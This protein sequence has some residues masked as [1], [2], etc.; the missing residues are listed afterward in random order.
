[1]TAGT[2]LAAQHG[3]ETADTYTLGVV[4][5][6]PGR[7]EN[8]TASLDIYTIEITDVI[9]PVNSLFVY[10]QC[11][12]ADGQ[13][14]PSLSIND[15]GG[16]CSMIGRNFNTGERDTVQ[17]PFVNQ[18]TLETSGVDLAVN[19]VTDFSGGSSFYVNS[20]LSVL[21]EFKLQDSPTEPF[22]DYKGTLAQG[23]QYDYRLNTTFGYNFGGGNATLGVRWVHLPEIEDQAKARQPNATVLGVGSYNLFSLF[24]GYEINDRMSLRGGID[25]LFDEQP[26][27]VGS[28]PFGPN[29][30]RNAA[31]TNAQYYD[32]LGRRAYVGLKMSF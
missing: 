32:I 7:F 2:A 23:G 26:P 20:M 12:N 13:S 19:W 16:Y 27:I 31:S 4:F 28:D 10:A 18:G 21:N 11:F 30:N 22:V 1:M 15:P 3:A 24:A 5:A 14:N 25:N 29:P 17:A 6:G 8:L 9:S